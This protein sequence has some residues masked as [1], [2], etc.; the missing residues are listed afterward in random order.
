MRVID[1]QGCF[2]T[3]GMLD[4]IGTRDCYV[5]LSECYRTEIYMQV[6]SLR[7]LPF[8]HQFVFDG[9]LAPG[10]IQIRDPLCLEPIIHVKNVAVPM[11]L[12]ELPLSEES[13]A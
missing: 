1:A 11:S 2:P 6:S 7:G 4:K 12:R 10:I 5:H 8:V 13:H 9:R 3:L